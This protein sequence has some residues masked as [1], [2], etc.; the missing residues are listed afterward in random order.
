MS[1]L[2]PYVMISALDHH[3]LSWDGEGPVA[4]CQLPALLIAA[5]TPL[6]DL[7]HMSQLCPHLVVGLNV[8]A[9]NFNNRVVPEEVNAMIERFLVTTVN[10]RGN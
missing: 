10:T 3:I 7:E 6:A 1:A 4:A 9:G 5:A 2:S 8:G